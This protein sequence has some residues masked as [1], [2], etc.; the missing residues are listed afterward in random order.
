MGKSFEDIFLNYSDPYKFYSSTT[1]AKK[2]TYNLD[3]ISQFVAGPVLFS[4]IWWVLIEARRKGI[5]TLYFLARD[6]YV[7][8]NIASDFCVKY[9]LNIECRYLYC[10]RASLRIPTYH[11]IGNEAY[12]LLFLYGYQVTPYS[13][14]SRIDLS[15]AERSAVYEEIGL[16]FATENQ[17]LTKRAFRNLTQKLRNSKVFQ[18]YVQQKSK[19]AYAYTI[20]YLQQEK[21]LDCNSVAIVD[22]GWTGSMQRSLRQLLE[23]AGYRGS[24]TGFYFGMFVDP[25]EEKDGEYLTWYFNKS[26]PK[27][28]KILFCNNL[29]ECI[30]SAPHGMTFGYTKE[31][32][33]YLPVLAETPAPSSLDKIN[34]QL[35]GILSFAEQALHCTNFESFNAKALYKLT[36]KLIH[37]LMAFPTKEEVRIY[38]DFLFCDDTTECY[39]MNLADASQVQQ[40][41]GYLILPRIFRRILSKSESSQYAELFW[42][43]GTLAFVAPLN[44]IW[45]RINIYIWEW[46]RYTVK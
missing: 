15:D 45:Y 28:D 9:S 8:Q 7:L 18:K 14:L 1:K 5:K 35:D 42:P 19:A 17:R 20:G 22:S 4:Y 25:K 2:S 30:L 33:K 13:L 21:L 11:L 36:Q 39:Q 32:G 37:R 29:F 12:D 16:M 23:S 34:T 24:I 40:L 27:C 31:N 26:S 6:G 10:S 38:G 46:F 44:Q 3:R 41:R 43:Y